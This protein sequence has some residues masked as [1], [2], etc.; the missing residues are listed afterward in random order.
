MILLIGF[1]SILALTWL[2]PSPDNPEYP[3]TGRS[4]ARPDHGALS[5]MTFDEQTQQAFE[6]LACRFRDEIARELREAA[7]DVV[8]RAR[9]ER[10]AAVAEASTRVRADVEQATAGELQRAVS[11]AEARG[12]DAA[13][14]QAHEEFSQLERR[15]QEMAEAAAAASAEHVRATRSAGGRVIEAVRALDSARSLSEIL[16]TLVSCASREAA[17]VGVL[18]AP[19]GALRGWRFLGF[20]PA[21]EP[22]AS[23]VV[24]PE[25]SGIIA[26]AIRTG[27]RVSADA[28]GRRAPLFAQLPGGRESL[29][30]PLAVGGDVVAVLYADRGERDEAEQQPT[31]LPWPDTLELL[32]RHAARCLEAATAGKAIRVLAG[33]PQSPSDSSHEESRAA[34]DRESPSEDDEAPQRYARLLVSEIKLYHAAAVA[35]GRREHNLSERLGAEI[36]R[37][38]VLYEQRIPPE[39]R[40]HIDHFHDELVRTLADG[41]PTLLGQ[42]V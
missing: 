1:E 10:N 5:P 12:R 38:R 22:A 24:P 9:E 14:R 28:A 19:I 18:L 21:F 2:Y 17:R 42:P 39:G 26:E 27:D 20:G 29:A 32:A 6:T 35:A 13:E 30:V 34:I 3:H 4:A 16:D 41:D 33:H 25:D 31:A 23:I 7:A 8:A 11:E 37:A 36:A 15:A 40:G